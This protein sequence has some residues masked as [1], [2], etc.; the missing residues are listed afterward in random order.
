L[1]G[2]V[3]LIVIAAITWE[4]P[5]VWNGTFIAGL[6]FV[7]LLGNAVAWVLWLYILNS[8]RAGTA[9][10]ATLLT[11]IIGIVSAWIQLGERP[12]LVEGLGMIAIVGALLLT[13]ARELLATR[14]GRKPQPPSV[15]GRRS[16]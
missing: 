10:L 2:A 7:A 12:D 5:P 9:G 13:V 16:P 4:G 11:P 1:I 6:I 8:F 15:K 3:P 14:S